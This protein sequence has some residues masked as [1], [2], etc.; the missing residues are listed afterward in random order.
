MYRSASLRLTATLAV[1]K[2]R[3]PFEPSLPRTFSAKTRQRPVPIT[4][5]EPKVRKV[6]TRGAD[7][8][9]VIGLA[10]KSV[11]SRLYKREDNERRV[12]EEADHRKWRNS[13]NQVCSSFEFRPR[14]YCRRIWRGV[15]SASPQRVPMADAPVKLLSW[16]CL[17]APEIRAR[18]I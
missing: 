18:L 9:T 8:N 4:S 11:S 17:R 16:N 15:G 12:R 6:P 7:P 13:S 10:V 14:Y 3:V 5:R 1:R 2:I